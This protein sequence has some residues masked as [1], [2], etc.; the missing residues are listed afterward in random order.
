[1]LR[2]SF[3]EKG[4]GL[5]EQFI[6][7]LSSLPCLNRAYHGVIV[8]SNHLPISI[9]TPCLN[10]AD[11]I[12]EAIESVRQ[13]NYPCLEHLIMDGGSTDGTLEVLERYPGLRVI[14]EPDEGIYD[15]LNK[16]I[17]LARGEV[18]GFLNTDDLYEPD[19]FEAVAQMFVRNPEIEALVG[20]ASIFHKTPQGAQ[21]TLTAFPCVDQNQLLARS[22]QGAP[23]FNAWFFRK[24]LFEELG[25]FDTRYRYV[26]DR[27]MLIRMAFQGYRYA[28]LDKPVYCYRMHP[29]SYTL[30]GTDS[31][32]ADYM[33]ECRA[34]AERYLRMRGVPREELK[35][36]RTWYSDIILEQVRSSWRLGAY[37][38][39]AGYM[40]AGLRFNNNWPLIFTRKVIERLP[41]ILGR[42]SSDCS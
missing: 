29:G 2:S 18:I 7:E 15:A 1:M 37:R 30:S 17:D 16:G 5:T 32:E 10:R 41:H 19:I 27:D 4:I 35:C 21:V 25:V 26:A 38:R 3:G 42:K 40:L 8:M 34:L 20:G 24:G 11:L 23:I 33:F 12:P 14:S 9:I 6:I 22:T 31:G 36:F 13:Q 28:C 39:M